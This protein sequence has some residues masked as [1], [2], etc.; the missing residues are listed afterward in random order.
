MS[1]LQELLTIKEAENL[2]FDV[3]KEKDKQENKPDEEKDQ[4]ND[5]EENGQDGSNKPSQHEK[6]GKEQIVELFAKADEADELKVYV[7]QATYQ[8]KQ[9]QQDEEVKI[10]WPG[11]QATTKKANAEEYI[12][13]MPEQLQ[14]LKVIEEDELE[15]KY[16][17]VNPNEKP[18]AEGFVVYRSKQEVLAFQYTEKELLKINVGG[19]QIKISPEDYVGHPVSN[20][21]KLL[22]ISKADFEKKYRLS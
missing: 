21:K 15:E 5:A 8:I 20:P 17:Q 16:E 4:E 13:R 6:D 18:D 11:Q 7:N 22:V 1:L 14:K 9:A 3:D 10:N 2:N 12:V 19:H